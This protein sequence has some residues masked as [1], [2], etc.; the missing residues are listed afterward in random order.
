MRRCLVVGEV[1]AQVDRGES[2]LQPLPAAAAILAHE[3]VSLEQREYDARLAP[4]DARLVGEV[5][6][7]HRLG[8]RHLL[9][10]DRDL[11]RLLDVRI[12]AAEE[13]RLHAAVLDAIEQRAHGAGSPSRPA[14]PAS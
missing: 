2:V 8:E 10:H 3:A 1:G 9:E 11:R 13:V 7:L 5:V 4:R 14:R 6:E 12:L